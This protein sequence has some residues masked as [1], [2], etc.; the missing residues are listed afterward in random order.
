MIFSVIISILVGSLIWLDRVFMFQFMISRPIVLAPILG[1][2]MGNLHIGLLVGASLELLWLNAPPVGAYLPNDDSFCAAV[3]T[4]VAAFAAASMPETSAAGLALVLCIPFSLM[5]RAL[6]MHIRTANQELL[7]DTTENLEPRIHHAMRKAL[8]RSYVCAL[9]AIGL[10]TA[11]LCG[12]V[13]LTRDILPGFLVSAL[14]YMPFASIII[15]LAA[16]ISKDMP[17]FSQ[18]GFFALGMAAVIMMTWIF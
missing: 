14:S 13:F 6:D 3:A 2:L 15:G 18:A 11:L 16:L 7:P 4:P 12:A 5:G 17:R 1:L 10:S 8:L 9:S